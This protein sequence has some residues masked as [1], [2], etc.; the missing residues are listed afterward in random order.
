MSE[1]NPAGEAHL[2]VE[3]KEVKE[4]VP[5]ERIMKETF[6]PIQTIEEGQVARAVEEAR[7]RL[8]STPLKEYPFI[9]GGEHFLGSPEEFAL[10]KDKGLRNYLQYIEEVHAATPEMITADVLKEAA[11]TIRTAVRE[12]KIPVVDAA[13]I[14]RRIAEQLTSAGRGA[15]TEREKKIR[16]GKMFSLRWTRLHKIPDEIFLPS[17]PRTG[18]SRTISPSYTLSEIMEAGFSPLLEREAVAI[19]E[20]SQEDGFGVAAIKG[21]FPLIVLDETMATGSF[22]EIADRLKSGPFPDGVGRWLEIDQET[23]RCLSLFLKL[24]GY[25]VA[26]EPGIQDSMPNL[27]AEGKVTREFF[28]L[29]PR[30]ETKEEEAKDREKAK[31]A[32]ELDVYLKA[33]QESVG[34]DPG[35]V[36]LAFTIFRYFGF[37]QGI[38]VAQDLY[39]RHLHNPR[40]GEGDLELKDIEPFLNKIKDDRSGEKLSDIIASKGVL[41]VA[42]ILSNRSV[43]LGKLATDWGDLKSL[44]DVMREV[45]NIRKG[46]GSAGSLDPEQ[47][48]AAIQKLVEKDLGTLVAK[49][50]LSQEAYK[51]ILDPMRISGQPKQ[52]PGNFVREQT[53]FF[54]DVEAKAKKGWD[55]LGNFDILAPFG[56]KKPPWRK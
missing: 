50:K 56:V 7:A 21:M 48:F 39:V 26:D 49:R 51:R 4:I 17:D 11:S 46:E 13:R 23:R 53:L 5:R 32:R 18:I 44:G 29:A 35:V 14:T 15:E 20:T 43:P 6:R 54:K 10:V 34:T 33:V 30:R 37:P 40:T 41:G 8:E 55:F 25:K 28:E 3:K 47:R 19:A 16:E 2:L 36:R 27:K 42:N 1:T 38:P 52:A 9:G 45:G 24:H 31:I 12:N 22:A